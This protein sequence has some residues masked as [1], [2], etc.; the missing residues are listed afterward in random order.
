[1]PAQRIRAYDA[2]GKVVHEMD[3]AA[4]GSAKF[5]TDETVTRVVFYDGPQEAESVVGAI[6]VNQ[7]GK[8]NVKLEV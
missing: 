2:D 6:D 5:S 8:I 3:V 7:S 4:D 1:M